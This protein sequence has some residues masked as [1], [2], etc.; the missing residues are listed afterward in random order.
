MIAN[1]V[2]L[3]PLL[4]SGC[5]CWLMDIIDVVAHNDHD[6]HDCKKTSLMT[7]KK[8]CNNIKNEQGIR[9]GLSSS[10][11]ALGKIHKL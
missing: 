6:H 11:L 1:V 9:V 4:V 8:K 5:C 3:L 10:S 7:Y 2:M